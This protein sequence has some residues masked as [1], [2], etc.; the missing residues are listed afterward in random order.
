MSSDIFYDWS[1]T[2]LHPNSQKI[3]KNA[4][5]SVLRHKPKRVLDIGCGN[6]YLCKILS[7]NNVECVGI[8]PTPEAIDY[9]K[10]F[11]PKS[12][13]YVRSCYD[14]P[15]NSDLGKFDVVISTEVIEHLY[16]PRKLVEFAKAHLKSNGVLILTTPDYG[17]YWR[18]LMIAIANRWDKHHT[19]LWDGGHIKFWS[20]TTL[21]ELFESTG[22]HIEMWEGTRSRI[23]IFYMS[24]TC[25]AR[26][27]DK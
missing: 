21:E 9:A 3:T 22:F 1:N 26:L 18:N 23:P 16:F 20:K 7:E 25:H 2:C 6:G 5:I 27:T 12:Q 17:S 13:F 15:V 24:I 8:E 4:A 19:P 11:A 14:N 10:T